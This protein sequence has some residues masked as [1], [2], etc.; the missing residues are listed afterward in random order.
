VPK[1]TKSNTCQ[2]HCVHCNECFASL[3]AFDAHLGGPLRRFRHRDPFRVKELRLRT[4]DGQCKHQV[5]SERFEREIWEHAE[6]TDIAR[7]AFARVEATRAARR[8][9]T[10]RKGG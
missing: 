2:W 4:E 1:Y 9:R 6:Q 7:A 5:A 8:P 3:L 10:P